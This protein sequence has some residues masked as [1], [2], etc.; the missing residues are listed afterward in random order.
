MELDM[1]TMPVTLR[2]SHQLDQEDRTRWAVRL[3][4]S[5]FG[6]ELS[7]LSSGIR[8]LEV[9]R[10]CQL[11]NL[12]VHV[13]CV[14]TRQRKVLINVYVYK[15]CMLL[16]VPYVAP[17]A[18]RFRCRTSDL[19]FHPKRTTNSH[20]SRILL[21]LQCFSISILNTTQN[22]H[23]NP[24]PHRSIHA[25]TDIRLWPTRNHHQTLLRTTEPS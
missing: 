18:L 3:P 15:R 6:E 20:R 21:H 24:K 16:C 5:T 23:P 17:R 22:L 7:I 1:G 8:I 12:Q 25:R 2:I 13:E 11:E 4:S 14:K 10:C 9:M 19:A